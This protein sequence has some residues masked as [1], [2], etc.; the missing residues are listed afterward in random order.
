VLAEVIDVL[1]F[2]LDLKGRSKT[3]ALIASL[4]AISGL[5]LDFIVNYLVGNCGLLEIFRLFLSGD[6]KIT[7]A[8]FFKSFTKD[9]L[10]PHLK[11]G[12]CDSQI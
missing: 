11:N 2:L 5:D 6:Q 7:F 12:D 8:I 10:L 3:P 9:I 1:M 4:D